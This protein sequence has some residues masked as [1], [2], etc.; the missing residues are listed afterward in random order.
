MVSS[1]TFISRMGYTKGRMR[2][3]N[4]QEPT[5]KSQGMV[6]YAA[7]G[8]PASAVRHHTPRAYV[9]VEVAQAAVTFC[10]SVKLCD[11]WN[12]EPRR[13]LCPDGG[14]EPVS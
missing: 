13:E 10:S 11:L 7:E 8:Y 12:P 2:L 5:Y 4:P 14:T 9:V 3:L 1:L 6:T